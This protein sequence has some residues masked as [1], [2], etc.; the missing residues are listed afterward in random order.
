MV[1]PEEAVNNLQR[2]EIRYH[3]V[4][5]I[6]IVVGF[7]IILLFVNYRVGK[8]TDELKADNATNNRKT[9]QALN[10]VQSAINKHDEN[11]KKY[12][13]TLLTQLE[14]LKPEQFEDC[15]KGDLLASQ[16]SQQTNAS[17]KAPPNTSQVSQN[18]NPGSVA[19]PKNPENPP[20]NSIKGFF[21]GVVKTVR[22]LL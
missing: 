4:K 12:V 19:P 2:T 22:N 13:C 3:I 18:S 8:T 17:A 14:L 16:P 10:E 9:E 5:A 15:L 11:T 21:M 1:S 6:I 20:D 7:I